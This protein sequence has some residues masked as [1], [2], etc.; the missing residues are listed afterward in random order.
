MGGERAVVFDR[1]LAMVDAA[2]AS[3]DTAELGNLRALAAYWNHNPSIR[4]RL[5]E[6]ASKVASIESLSLPE[7]CVNYIAAAI[8]ARI[9]TLTGKYADVEGIL[10]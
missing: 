2:V 5:T 3:N 10:A 8:Y 1:Y 6:A 7:K 4:P 9:D